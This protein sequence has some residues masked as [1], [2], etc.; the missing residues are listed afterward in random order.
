MMKLK[1]TGKESYN[2]EATTYVLIGFVL[3]VVLLGTL[4]IILISA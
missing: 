4:K 2:S 3:L 1:F